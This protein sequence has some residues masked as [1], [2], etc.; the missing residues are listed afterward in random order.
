MEEDTPLLETLCRPGFESALGAQVV[1]VLLGEIVVPI[2]LV[3]PFII[4]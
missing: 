4:F 3:S 1:D 2:S